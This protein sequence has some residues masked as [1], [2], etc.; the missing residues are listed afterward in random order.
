MG[1][2]DVEDDKGTGKTGEEIDPE[3][4]PPPPPPPPPPPGQ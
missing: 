2:H 4:Y 1:K 3:K